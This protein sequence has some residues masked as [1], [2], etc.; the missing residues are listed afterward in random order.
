MSRKGKNRNEW[1]RVSMRREEVRVGESAGWEGVYRGERERVKVDGIDFSVE[2]KAEAL[3]RKEAK[4]ELE[5][6]K[7]AKR[8]SQKLTKSTVKS[9]QTSPDLI[10]C[11]VETFGDQPPSPFT[12][13]VAPISSDFNILHG[14]S[15]RGSTSDKSLMDNT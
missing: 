7:T 13:S 2:R 6:R 9:R 12:L 11:H 10:S 14:Q 3:R 5:A 8:K 15:H 4:N 1:E